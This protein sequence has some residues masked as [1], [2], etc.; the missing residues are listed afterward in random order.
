MSGFWQ[1][2]PI[3]RGELG[4]RMMGGA[5]WTMVGFAYGNA[6]RLLS[7]VI[8]TRLLS[9]EAYGLMSIALLVMTG[10]AMLSDIGIGA[11][12]IRSPRGEDPDFLNTA[13]V[14]KI[15]RGLLIGV[16]CLSLAWPAARFYDEPQLAGLI[17]VLALLPVLAGFESIMTNVMQRRIAVK[18]PTI[19]GAVAATIGVAGTIATALIWQSVWALVVGSVISG[20][21]TLI[22]GY[23]YLPRFRHRFRINRADAHELIRFGS[24]ILAATAIGYLGG[25]GFSLIEA[26]LV[27]VAT[28]GLIALANTL[29]TALTALIEKIY[30][31]VVFP[32]LAQVHRDQ[33]ADIAPKLRRM[34]KLLYALLLPLFVLLAVVAQPVV[35]LLYDPRYALAGSFLALIALQSGIGMIPNVYNNLIIASG[36]SR[37]HALLMVASLVLR[38]GCALPGF[39]LGG[40]LGMV[41]GSGI[42]RIAFSLLM[43]AVARRLGYTDGRRDTGALI[44]MSAIYAL[45]CW[46]VMAG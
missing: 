27:P 15:I 14:I 7:T 34:Q 21:L 37:K 42:G 33:P 25:Q 46:L 31:S 8:V 30:A 12:V 16:I 4:Q 17:A 35:N 5:A 1:R 10:L 44:A 36:D 11:S 19:I 22:L 39:Y 38:L 45:G 29:S 26:A 2:L 43:I 28:L 41:A 32:A 23:A 40:A 3:A 20:A 18:E 24:W 13:W 6:L 9:P